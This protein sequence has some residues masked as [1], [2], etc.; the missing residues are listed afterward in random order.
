MKISPGD[1]L[2]LNDFK[3]ELL[4]ATVVKLI[5]R[6]QA[7]RPLSS[8]S[9]VVKPIDCCERST[10]VKPIDCCERSTVVSDR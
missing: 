2:Q 9:T 8:R 6:C 5:D 10:V 1:R 4:G 3:K 7:D